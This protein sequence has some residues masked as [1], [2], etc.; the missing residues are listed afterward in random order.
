MNSVLLHGQTF[1]FTAV[2]M[3]IVSS[4]EAH[5]CRLKTWAPF[6]RLWER[7]SRLYKSTS[8]VSNMTQFEAAITF[9]LFLLN[10]SYIIAKGIEWLDGTASRFALL[11]F[12]YC[13]SN[14]Q[15]TVR[16]FFYAISNV[17]ILN[18]SHNEWKCFVFASS[19]WLKRSFHKIDGIVLYS[20]NF[21]I[22]IIHC[23]MFE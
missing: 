14:S 5:L 2:L 6:Q 12:D 23:M 7:T 10:V 15:N 9:L 18:K 1:V 19:M 21:Y 3:I 11:T 17:L 16:L 22:L 13:V 8:E 20:N 4:P